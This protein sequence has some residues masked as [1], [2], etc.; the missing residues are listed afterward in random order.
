MR[1][2]LKFDYFKYKVYKTTLDRVMTDMGGEIEK[3]YDGHN[4]LEEAI[5]VNLKFASL[6]SKILGLSIRLRENVPTLD[7]NRIIVDHHLSYLEKNG[8]R[9]L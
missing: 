8:Q 6:V 3:G 9:V 1:Q 7:P 4:Y 2:E 5:E